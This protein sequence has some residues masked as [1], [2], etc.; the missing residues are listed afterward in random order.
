MGQVLHGS[1]RAPSTY[2]RSKRP[3][4]SSS[5]SE[6]RP[7]SSSPR[8]T[9]MHHA[10][11]KKPASWSRTSARRPVRSRPPTAPPTTT[12]VGR[13]APSWNTNPPARPTT[14]SARSTRGH[15][16]R[17]ACQSPAN[18]P[19][20]RPPHEQQTQLRQPAWCYN[21]GIGTNARHNARR[22]RPDANGNACKPPGTEP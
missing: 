12:R 2:P 22:D 16:D 19:Q 17:S 13:G 7:M 5:C 3:L 1:A 20:E 10:S 6:N 15:V 14:T 11:T 8:A 9:P 18:P 4:S 21:A